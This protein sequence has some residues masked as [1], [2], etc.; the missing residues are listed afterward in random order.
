MSFSRAYGPQR[1]NLVAPVA[2]AAV[3]GGA[4]A[5]LAAVLLRQRKREVSEAGAGGGTGTGPSGGAA[6]REK[7][8]EILAELSKRFFLVCQDVASI[9]RTVRAK[10]E[11]S[12]VAIT[13]EKLREQLSRQCRVFERLEEIQSEVSGQF[14][15]TPE[16]VRGMQQRAAKDADVQAYA[17]GFKTMLNDALG[18][19][20]PVM[21]KVRIPPELTEEKVLEIQA[22]VH[23]LE[24]RKV[25]EAV[26][27]SKCTVKKLG[28]VL[29][30]AHRDAWEQALASYAQ[31]V[32]GGPEVYHSALAIYMRS[33]DFASERKKLDEAHQQKMVKL[34]QP[35]GGAEVKPQ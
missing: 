35:D 13:D 2:V 6:E 17:E 12:N 9:S 24:I 34:F 15:S 32:Q 26:G 23:R 3:A 31:V 21:P 22:E 4:V 29:G 19:A 16:G 7:L 25:L 11:A 5:V 20:L 10:I 8:L 33:E 14:G 1:P 27:G 30:V 28:E 18:G